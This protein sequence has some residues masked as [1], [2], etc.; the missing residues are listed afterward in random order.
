MEENLQKYLLFICC[1]LFLLE[2]LFLGLG[3]FLR[4]VGGLESECIGKSERTLSLES[5]VNLGLD[6][7]IMKS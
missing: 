3:G 1:Q 2:T 6:R 5:L 7:D 4:G